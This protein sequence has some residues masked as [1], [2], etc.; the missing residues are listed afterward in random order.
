[1]VGAGGGFLLMPV[2]LMLYP[3]DSPQTLTSISL[4]VVFLNAGSGT[5]GYRRLGR[6]DYRA[7]LLFASATVPAGFAGV[8]V[9]YL[10]PRHAFNLTFGLVVSAAAVYLFLSPKNDSPRSVLRPDTRRSLTD[11]DGIR[12]TYAYN[13][14]LGYAYSLAVGFVATLLGIGGGSIHVAGMVTLLGFPVHVATA[15]SHFVLAVTALSATIAHVATGQF[16]HGWDRT[17]ALGSSVV[18]GAQIGARLARRTSGRLITR[19]LAVSLLVVGLRL[20]V[21]SLG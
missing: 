9:N 12:Y 8:A 19:L 16:V 15:T 17:L 6:I 5:L 2:L 13:G 20:V 14:K 1:M 4:A 21:E 3:T 18:I 7:G 10:L 11:A